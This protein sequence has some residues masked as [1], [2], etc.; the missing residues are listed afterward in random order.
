MR[1][2]IVGGG[3]SGLASALHLAPLVSQGLISSPI[4][5]FEASSRGKGRDIGVGIWSTALEPFRISDR[6]SHQMVWEKMTKQGSWIG[7]VGYRTPKGNWLVT[8]HLPTEIPDTSGEDMPGLLFLKEADVKSSLRLAVA[9]EENNSTVRVHASSPVTGIYEESPHA[10]SAP[11]TF[12]NGEVSE[13]DYHF[14]IAA[15]G[16]NSVLRKKYGGH[17]PGDQRRLTGTSAFRTSTQDADSA[18]QIKDWDAAR[19]EEIASLE[20]RKYTV[21]RGNSPVTDEEKGKGGLNFQTWGE[22]KSMRFATVNMTY[23]DKGSTKEEKQ[24]WFITIDDDNITSESDPEKRKTILL[25]AFASWHSPICDMVASTPADEIL[26]ERAVAH[27][28]SMAPVV[29]MNGVLTE[30]GQRRP[31][32]SGRGPAMVFIGDAFMTVDPSE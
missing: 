29:D 22:G 27:S 4:D 17:L 19:Q 16:I 8:S 25:D 7:E 30:I 21:F 14:I 1:V 32:S 15:D 5:L 10:W 13:R 9:A 23:P 6:P 12:D 3:V 24:V 2:A 18:Q 26:M 31:P 28:H 11:L 20:D